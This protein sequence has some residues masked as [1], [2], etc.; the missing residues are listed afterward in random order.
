VSPTKICQDVRL[1][2]QA[3]FTQQMLTDAIVG[4]IAKG[5]YLS[6]KHKVLASADKDKFL[7]QLGHIVGSDDITEAIQPLRIKYEFVNK[8]GEI[9]YGQMPQLIR[10]TSDRAASDRASRSELLLLK[11]YSFTFRE[12]S[13]L[14]EILREAR[15]YFAH[16]T[17]DREDIGWNG[18]I[19]SAVTRILERANFLDKKRVE[20]RA[21]LRTRTTRLFKQL[22][23]AQADPKLTMSPIETD[24]FSNQNEEKT[25]DDIS[26]NV[27][28][29]IKSLSSN[30]EELLSNARSVEFQLSSI[31]KQIGELKTSTA[32]SLASPTQ[33]VHREPAAEQPSSETA[34]GAEVADG[35]D[36]AFLDTIRPSEAK[37]D[38][39]EEGPLLASES[40]I[41]VDMLYE[42]LQTLK[43]KIRSRYENDKRWRGP[44]SNF[45]QKA[46][47]TA[48]VTNEPD[49]ITTVLK[50]EDVKWRVRKEK[51]LLTEQTKIFGDS[52]NKLLNRTAWT[53]D[54]Q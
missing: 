12:L 30:Q 50:Y 20:E 28:E 37:K 27:L 13:P 14:F 5:V 38:D 7:S 49:S 52:I 44:S 24:E 6:A 51:D 15:N 48:I 46:I 41:S 26:P 35:F 31:T 16:N 54:Y 53:K 2:L 11:D 10:A 23:T 17:A 34:I 39:L 1:L 36:H 3:R 45:L 19:I 22:V 42:E 9:R 32:Q 25:I 18:L 4:L 21:N 33:K 43:S 47:V 40:L 29:I 8:F